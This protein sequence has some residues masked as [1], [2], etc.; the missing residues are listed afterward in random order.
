MPAPPEGEAAATSHAG[1]LL[2]TNEDMILSGAVLKQTAA[3]Q[4]DAAPGDG[5]AIVLEAGDNSEEDS[6][7]DE[8]EDDQ[9]DD[10]QDEELEDPSEDI[11]VRHTH[12]TIR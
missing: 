10:D 12:S 11:K 6:Q 5:P 3:D 7:T 4:A 1:V 9:D 2:A 8:D